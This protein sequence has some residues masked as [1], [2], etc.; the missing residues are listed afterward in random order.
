MIGACQKAIGMLLL[1]SAPCVASLHSASYTTSLASGVT[2]Y[3]HEHGRRYHAYRE[4]EYVFPNDE[5][6]IDRLDITHT[7][8]TIAMGHK[9]HSAPLTDPRRILDIGTGTGVWALEMAQAFPDSQVL[10]NDLSPIQPRW[11]Q[12]NVRFEVD[13]V[14]AEWAYREPFDFVHCRGMYAS[15]SDWPALVKRAFEHTTPGGYAEFVDFDLLWRSPDDSYRGTAMEKANQTFMET[16]RKGGKEPCPGRYLKKWLQDAGFEDVTEKV[17]VIP[18]GTWPA[19]KHLKE[20]GAWNYL[21]VMEGL[22]GF[23]YA[24]FIRALGWSK[25][26]VDELCEKVRQDMKNPK[27]HAYVTV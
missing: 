11:V 12:P 14:E 27:F 26:D 1:T 22:E 13:D 9:L 16:C 21:Q 10:G 15:I 25:R 8:L 2:D 19:D 23:L 4:G 18:A 7:M 20:V 24:V 6:E 17:M 3:K 5:R